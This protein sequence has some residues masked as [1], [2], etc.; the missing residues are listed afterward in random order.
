MKTV[1]LNSI[2]LK[3]GSTYL[4][5]KAEDA[6]RVVKGN[7]LLYIVPLEKG[8]AGRRAFLCEVQEGQLFPAFAYQDL[9]YQQWRFCLAAA[10][11]A[12]LESMSGMS[13]KPLKENFRKMAKLGDSQ[14]ESFENLLVDYYRKRLVQEDAYLIKTSREKRDTR[15][16]VDALIRS[17]FEREEYQEAQQGKQAL[18]QIVSLLCH[19]SRIAIAPYEKIRECCGE[20]A[21][22]LDIARV[23][24]FPCREIVLEENWHKA[25]AGALLVLFGEGKEM[26]ACVPRGQCGYMLYRNGQKPVKLTRALA[27]ACAPKA[28]MVYRPFP[29]DALTKGK[30]LKYCLGAMRTADVLAVSLLTVISS[31]IGLLLPTLNQK[32]YDTYIPNGQGGMIVQ[33]CFL[34]LSF[35]AGNIIFSI[36]KGIGQF[37]ISSHIQCQVQNAVYYRVF[38]LPE[39]FFR[40]YES[41]DL[42]KRILELG[43]LAQNAADLGITLLFSVVTSVFYFWKM[44]TYSARLSL[45]SLFLSLAF[46]GVI[47]VISSYQLQHERKV[48]E[49]DGRSDSVLFQFLQGMDKVRISGIEERAV[50][51]Y[52][53]PY[54]EQR[55]EEMKIGRSSGLLSAISQISEQAVCLALYAVAYHLFGITMGVFVA[56]TSAFG[57]VS[58]AIEELTDGIVSYQRLKPMYERVREILETAPE[59]DEGK[60]LPGDISGQIAIN[61][62]SFAYDEGSPMIFEDL[63]L[64]FREGEYVGIVGGSGCGKSTLLKLLLGFERPMAGRIYYDSQDMADVNLQELRKKFGVVL[65]DGELI[66]GSIFDNI[67]L[68]APWAGYQDVEQVVQQVGLEQDI[69]HMPMGL[70]TLVSEGC[71]TISG[72]QKQ[73]ILIARAIINRPKLVFFDEATSAL[74]NI[75]QGMVCKAL[76]EMDATR[77]VIAHRLSTIQRCDRILVLEKGKV[78]EEGDYEGLMAHKGLFYRLA[79]RQVAEG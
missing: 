21:T 68:T 63:S 34:I 77:I 23:S 49:L 14:G 12:T 45:V 73:R 6:Y 40:R 7:V 42:A 11:E 72:G 31:L 35:L 33:I 74:D 57:Y 76:E 19:K 4:T 2:Y 52:L 43:Q 54:V 66:S 51:E 15:Q 44:F 56:F 32:L 53:K 59:T 24:H 79:S 48:M 67:A 8:R 64:D 62:V 41:A 36:L 78:V 29:E 3:G 9:D 60:Q 50:Y 27:E 69:A 75:T 1:A 58:Q 10:E 39:S 70:Q 5:P 26:A 13:T 28:Y 65:Q 25:D 20:Q 22:V 37:R 47:S 38:Q 30:L 55:K 61:H 71:N 18:Y 46:A 16:R 17:A